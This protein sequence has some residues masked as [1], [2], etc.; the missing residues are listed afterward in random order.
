VVE[1]SSLVMFLYSQSPVIFVLEGLLKMYSFPL[2][3]EGSK[4]F[5]FSHNMAEI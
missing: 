3:T 1:I 5:L 2:L 4:F